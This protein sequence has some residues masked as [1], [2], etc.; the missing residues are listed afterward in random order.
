MQNVQ[1]GVVEG[2]RRDEVDGQ[3]TRTA[4]RQRRA[5]LLPLEGPLVCGAVALCSL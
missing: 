5:L 2:P 4:V 3:V 1:H